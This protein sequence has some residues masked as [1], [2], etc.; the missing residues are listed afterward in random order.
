MLP[1]LQTFILR[2]GFWLID[3]CDHYMLIEGLLSEEEAR[4]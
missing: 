3:E 4:Y 1:T 2:E